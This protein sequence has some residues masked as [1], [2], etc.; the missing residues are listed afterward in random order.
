[1]FIIGGISEVSSIQE[2]VR[3]VIGIGNMFG[4]VGD[5]EKLFEGHGEVLDIAVVVLVFKEE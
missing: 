3:V 4:W 2:I 5:L 1:L